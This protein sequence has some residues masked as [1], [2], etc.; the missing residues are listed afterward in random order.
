MQNSKDVY[1]SKFDSEPKAVRNI[2]NLRLLPTRN[3]WL[4][5]SWQLIMGRLYTFANPN[6]FSASSEGLQEHAL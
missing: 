4:V 6:C 1:D 3:M 2:V 5:F